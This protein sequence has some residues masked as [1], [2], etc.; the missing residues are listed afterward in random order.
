MGSATRRAQTQ[1]EGMSVPAGSDVDECAVTN[2]GVSKIVRITW[3]ASPV[4][5]MQAAKRRR[6]T[7]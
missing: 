5:V 6:R 2:G 4:R 1:L 7:L 3:V